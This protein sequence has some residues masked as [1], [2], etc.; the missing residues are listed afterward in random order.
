MP[1]DK[2]ASYNIKTGSD[3]KRQTT[4]G[5]KGHLNVDEDGFVKTY[6]Y[7]TGSLH[8]SKALKMKFMQSS[9]LISFNFIGSRPDY[10]I[11]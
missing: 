2:D 9:H 3:G 8:D 1:S 6:D 4:Y 11:D 5:F 7:S 10:S